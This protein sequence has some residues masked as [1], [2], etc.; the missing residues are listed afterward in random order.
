VERIGHRGWRIAPALLLLAVVGG[1]W[2]QP[3][4][5]PLRQGSNPLETGLT[6][7]NVATLEPRWTVAVDDGPVRADP[8]VSGRGLLHVS[9][10]RAVYGLDRATGA[11]AWRTPVVPADVPTSAPA[12][13]GMV[14]SNDTQVFVSWSGIP[15][16]G[17]SLIVDAATGQ[18]AQNRRGMIGARSTILRDPWRVTGS[19]GFVESTLAGSLITVDGPVSWSVLIDLGGN[20]PLPPP[21]PV[22]ITS[23]RFFVGLTGG[24]QGTNVLNGWNLDRDCGPVEPPLCRPD[25]QT[26][27][28]GVPTEAV[29]ADGEATVY[30]ATAAGTVYAVSTATG[31]VQWTASLGAPVTQRMAWTP[32]A[33]YA[34]TDNGR[35][36]TLD[37]GGCGAATCSPTGSVRLAGTPAAAPAVAGGVVY[38]ASAAGTVEAFAVAGGS[39]PLWSTSLGSEVTGGPTVAHGALFVGTAGGDVIAF[40]PS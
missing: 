23:T 13:P 5:G 24:F 40:T 31:A 32:D 12:H 15:D 39:K 34:V 4:F 26:Q 19:S 9:D 10:D 7:A 3:G 22:A 16:D 27:L 21:T 25:V 20:Q 36:V 33:L 29:I 18:V 1:C 17:G 14:S 2:R 30:V 11:R 37:P 8:V 38:V 6:A 35:L 28:D